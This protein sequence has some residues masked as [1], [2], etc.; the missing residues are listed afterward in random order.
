MLDVIKHFLERDGLL[1]VQTFVSPMHAISF[2][3]AYHHVDFILSDYDMPGMNGADFL[4]YIR[5]A[6]ITIPFILYTSREYEEVDLDVFAHDAVHFM[7]KTG[8]IEAHMEQLIRI[9][10]IYNHQGKGVIS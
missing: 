7:S 8:P 1:E 4:Y 10:K 5:S 3:Q 2:L 9:I 6:G